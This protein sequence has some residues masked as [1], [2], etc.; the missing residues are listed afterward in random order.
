MKKR[1]SFMVVGVIIYALIIYLISGHEINIHVILAIIFSS[2]VCLSSLIPNLKLVQIFTFGLVFALIIVCGYILG[3]SLWDTHAHANMNI[4][5]T[6]FCSPIAG[7]LIVLNCVS[8][9][10]KQGGANEE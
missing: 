1:M 3:L 2:I 10:K 8:Y 7:L 6:L 5:A 4:V 9:V